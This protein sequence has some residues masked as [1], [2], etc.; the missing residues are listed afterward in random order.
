MNY[1][2]V[3]QVVGLLLALVSLTMLAPL[4]IA[5]GF[6]ETEASRAFGIS[7]AVGLAVS[8]AMSLIGRRGGGRF[9]RREALGVVASAWLVVA[10][11]GCLPYLLCGVLDGVIDAYFETMSGFTTT[12]ASVISSLENHPDGGPMPR[13]ILFWRCLT[14]WLGGVGIVVLFVAVLPALGVSS[15]QIFHM[16]A[17]GVGEKG[18][19]PHIRQ[20][21]LA[22]WLLYV[23]LTVA[24]F[25]SLMGAGL[26]WFD[27]LCHALA[28]LATG[29]FSSHT[30]SVGYYQSWVVNL[31]VTVFMFMAGINFSLYFRLLLRR[32]LKGF[33]GNAELRFYAGVVALAIVCIGM[34]LL[35]RDKVGS[36]GAALDQASF[37]VVTIA[38]TT[39]FATAD[40][41]A[42]PSLSQMILLLLM[43]TGGCAG[44]TSG[45]I[46]LFRVMLVLKYGVRQLRL[47]IR[48]R[49]VE[50]L[51]LGGASVT[52]EVIRPVLGMVIFFVASFVVGAIFLAALGCDLT[53]ALTASLAAVGNIGPGLGSVGPNGNY[54]AIPDAGK[55]V[56]SFLMLIG[57]LEI[58]TALSLFAPTLWRD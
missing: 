6:G 5:L 34:E 17:P 33:L 27:A 37:Q 50:K 47:H 11:V 30:A 18:F 31:I 35:F 7:I 40:F 36:V 12:G 9:Y 52:K 22:L 15:R 46:K 39:G 56:L 14:N 21:A 10:S 1:F 13:S 58:F 54:A 4:G 19:M 8:G 25:L 45:G 53:T 57:R 42:W 20:T 55:V 44:S 3:L 43:F 41:D 16:E 38:T 2:R 48:P 24:C 26:E 29:G 28:T 49:S 23:G 32:D 51:K